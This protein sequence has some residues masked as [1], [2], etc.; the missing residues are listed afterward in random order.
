MDKYEKRRLALKKLVDGIGHGANKLI[1][2]AIGIEPNYV[3][4]MLYPEGQKNKK[5]MGEDMVDKLNKKFAGWLPN[6][7]AID[8]EFTIINTLNVKLSAGAGEL[9][10]DYNAATP[11]SLRTDFLQSVGADPDSVFAFPIIGDSMK[12]AH[13]LNG[14]V[15]F[16][17]MDKQEPEHNAIYA[18]WSDNKYY[19]KKVVYEDGVWLAR[20]CNNELNLADLNMDNVKI[21]GKAFWCGFG[22]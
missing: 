9:V 10:L 18:L 5:R 2:E 6:E 19:I 16:I 15:V 22:L 3:S 12:D 17:N 8:S 11:L 14:S 1:A 13:I 7:N 4:R 21:V 20:S